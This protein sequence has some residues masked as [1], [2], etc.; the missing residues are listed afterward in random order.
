MVVVV[1]EGDGLDASAEN[2]SRQSQQLG[3]ARIVVDNHSTK[4]R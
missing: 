4:S 1:V 2:S 3:T